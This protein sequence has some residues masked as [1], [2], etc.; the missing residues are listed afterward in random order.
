MHKTEI[1][2]AQLIDEIANLKSENEKLKIQNFQM[3]VSTNNLH[4]SITLGGNSIKTIDLIEKSKQKEIEIIEKK[5]QELINKMEDEHKLFL[6][7]IDK[8]MLEQEN[9][10]NDSKKLYDEQV[11]K[12]K[13]FLIEN[14][15][16]K[17]KIIHLEEIKLADNNTIRSL[18]SELEKIKKNLINHVLL[19]L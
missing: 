1:K 12:I 19:V 5:Y 11:E 2:N 16:F 8:M 13:T 10:I 18:E 14:T 9:E 3:E 4:Q 15:D 7:E 6:E 17:K